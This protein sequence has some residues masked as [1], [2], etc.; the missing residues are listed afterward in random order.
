MQLE[1]LGGNFDYQKLNDLTQEI[2]KQASADPS[3]STSSPLSV[4]ARRTS[5]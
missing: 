1:M 4:P 3:C 2:V 5:R